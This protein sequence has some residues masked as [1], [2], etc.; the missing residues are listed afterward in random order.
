MQARKIL[1]TEHVKIKLDIYR[2]IY[3]DSGAQIF[4]VNP[5]HGTLRTVFFQN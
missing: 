1:K 3:K 5:T 4:I 2:I